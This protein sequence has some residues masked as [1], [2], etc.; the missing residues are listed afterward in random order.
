M[1][2]G[3][4]KVKWLM[5]EF[6][7]SMNYFFWLLA[8]KDRS[9]I[10]G[11]KQGLLGAWFSSPA[12]PSLLKAGSGYPGRWVYIP[13]WSLPTCTASSFSFP[14][15]PYAM[16]ALLQLGMV[17]ERA[18]DLESKRPEL[19]FRYCHLLITWHW[20]SHMVFLRLQFWGWNGQ[21]EHHTGL[22]WDSVR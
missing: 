2:S 1:C 15:K 9:F 6:V 19:Q 12:F 11:L 14:K 17:V 22:W 16:A 13:L 7:F 21:N 5:T 3:E 8:F 20:E 18:L 10:D 4:S